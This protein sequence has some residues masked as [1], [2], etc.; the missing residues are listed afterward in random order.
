MP[1]KTRLHRPSGLMY[2]V[3]DRI[4]VD[5]K[6]GTV[7]FVGLI[8]Q[9]GNSVALGVEWDDPTR[10]KNSGDID[11]KYVFRTSV[12]GAGS[13]VKASNKKIRKPVSFAEALAA[14]YSGEENVL[15]LSKEVSFG[16]KKV[17]TYGFEKLNQQRRDLE[18]LDT[19]GL[20]FLDINAAGDLSQLPLLQ[21][22]TSLDLSSNLLTDISEI[23]RIIQHCP[24]LESLNLNGNRIRHWDSKDQFPGIRDLQ[25]AATGFPAQFHLHER[26]PNL[27]KLNLS[28]NLLS[29][30]LD[31]PPSLVEIDLSYNNFQEIL[32]PKRLSRVNFSFNPINDARAQ[33]STAVTALDLRSTQ[34]SQWSNIDEIGASFPDLKELRIND[35]P[36]FQN[37]SVDEAVAGIIGR[38][39]C[40]G[41]N[42]GKGLYRLNGAALT[43]TEVENAELYFVS[44][45]QKKTIPYPSPERWTQLVQRYNVKETAAPPPT[46]DERILTLQF[47][48]EEDPQIVF[49][50]RFLYK[51][52]VL[53]LKG[54]VAALINSRVFQFQLYYYINDTHKVERT[55]LEDDIAS[56]AS[57]GLRNNQ[58]I[59]ILREPPSFAVGVT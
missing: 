13:F 30:A 23:S 39:Q 58:V 8:P 32:I 16:S 42:T 45:V 19:V 52:T 9:W 53:F 56:L 44:M 18:N 1:D 27:E 20:D 10:G 4:N 5:G 12:P 50:R 43:E 36:L 2:E 28:N 6:I 34:L 17:E 29:G 31:V 47:C 3:H 7:R 57:L 59:H 22:A 24:R 54:R 38:I 15:A 37:L 55:Y 40:T 26:F 11:G 51:A 25:V 49:T 48:Y 46:Q 41:T 35:C 21:L 14:K 33:V